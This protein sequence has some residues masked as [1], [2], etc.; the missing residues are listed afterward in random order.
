VS[1]AV[2]ATHQTYEDAYDVSTRSVGHHTREA[3]ATEDC[4][5]RANEDETVGN[6]GIERDR[7]SPEHGFLQI[8]IFFRILGVL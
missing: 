3:V 6:N 1:Q 5:G 2:E 8:F 7:P 4:D